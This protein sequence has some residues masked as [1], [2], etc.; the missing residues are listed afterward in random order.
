[1]ADYYQ[2][3]GVDRSASGDEIKKAYRKL[4]RDHHPDVNPD[5]PEA[6]ARFKELAKAYEV[7]S[8]P[9]ARSRYDRFGSDDSVNFGDPFGQGGMGGLNDLFDVFFGGQG[10]FGGSGGGG[11]R[12]RG[13]GPPQG[14]TLQV[15]ATLDFTDAV[16]GCEHEV[17]VVTAVTCDDCTGTGAAP[18]S[19]SQTCV[20]CAGSGETRSVRQ[21]LLG[22]I[23]SATVCRRCGGE[24]RIVP[25]PCP[26]CGGQGRQKVERNYTVSVPAG[27]DRGTVLRLTGRGAVGTRGG[28]PGDLY[29]KIDVRPHDRFERQGFDL[30]H[31][32]PISMT[33]A[34]LGHHMTYETL[35]GPEDMVIPKGTQSGRVLRLR[36]RGVPHGSSRGDLLVQVTV[37]T[38]QELTEEQEELLEKFAANR[39]EEI[40]RPDT[41]LFS[42]IRSAFK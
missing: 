5:D 14:E 21:T 25:D 10:P 34:A 32:M 40:V 29:I 33:Q 19:S 39:G 4:A 8:D 6:E 22:Q 15:V 7:L 35:D 13:G 9:E 26:T 16:F 38:P 2:T 30:V 23:V 24:G 3:L 12:Q 41:G 28:P 37:T 18:G 17:S 42:K 27:V 11:G 1:V 20:E 31:T 36:K